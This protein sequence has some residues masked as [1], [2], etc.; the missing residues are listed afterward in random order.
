MEHPWLSVLISC[1]SG[2]SLPG[3]KAHARL[4]AYDRPKAEQKRKDRAYK[5]SAVLILLYPDD[6]GN[7]HTIFIQRAGGR[8]VHSSQI[9]FPGGKREHSDP[10]LRSTALREAQEEVGVDPGNIRTLGT[11]TEI[12]IPPSGYIVAPYLAW[13]PERPSFTP[14]PREVKEILEA[15]IEFFIGDD[16]IGRR[17]VRAGKD[18]VRLLVPAYDCQG[19]TI[20]GATA[21]I[22]SE[23]TMMLEGDQ[24]LL[25]RHGKKG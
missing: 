15:P 6:Q 3:E 8:D 4:S 9:A 24:N 18:G 19:F 23:L 1:L 25:S 5:E 17:K 16:A 2:G 12:F 20:W 13:S 21:M 22:L 11:L 14:D 7:L 10:D